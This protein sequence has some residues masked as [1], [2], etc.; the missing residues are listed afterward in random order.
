M[1]EPRRHATVLVRLRQEERPMRCVMAAR[2]QRRRGLTSTGWSWLH[3]KWSE[4]RGV[5]WRGMQGHV[6]GRPCQ[7]GRE[8]AGKRAPSRRRAA[9]RWAGCGG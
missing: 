7:A 5:R 6:P 9:R 1:A 3:L 4:H 8:R 2:A